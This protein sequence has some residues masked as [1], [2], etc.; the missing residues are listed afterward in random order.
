[1]ADHST[2]IHALLKKHWGYDSFRPMQE[3]IITS[4]LD[5]HDT[6]G[7]L[8]TGGGKSI[9]FQ[10]PALALGGLTVVV[11][12]LISLMKDQV[13]NLR[14]KGILA[15]QLNHA[16]K[17]Y[18]SE[19]VLKRCELGKI[20]ILYLSPEK[21]RSPNM[22][23]W[24]NILDV[25]LIVVDEA[26]CISQW[27]YDFRPSY[28]KIGQLRERFPDVPVL[29]L[30]ASAT[31]QVVE[32]MMEKLAFRDK[33]H[34]FHLSFTRKNISYV[35]RHC[36]FKDV[37]LLHILSRVGG[38]GIV[39]TRSRKRTQ[40]LAAFL[41]SNDVSADY[42]HA[43]LS[44][45]EKN[46]R[47]NRWKSGETRIIVAT[48]AFGMGIDKPDVRIV[49]HHDLPSSL[50]E[51]Y[52]EA[53]RAGRDGLPSWAVVLTT[54]ADKGTLTRRLSESYPDKEFIR[55]TYEKLFIFLGVGMEEGFGKNFEFQFGKFC[56]R[57][58]LNP[59]MADSALRILSQA[60]YFDYTDDMT[61]PSRLIMTVSR[62]ALY[63]LNGLTEETERVLQ[64]IL[65]NYSGIF[66]DYEHIQESYIAS[67]LDLTERTVYEA[68]LRMR[69]LHIIDY[70]PRKRAPYIYMLRSREPRRDV[71]LP[72]TVYETRRQLME[73][74]LEAMK[75]FA[76]ND[77]TCRVETI[78]GYFGEKASPCGT[79]DVC[80]DRKKREIRLREHPRASYLSPEILSEAIVFVANRN[81]EGITIAN[82]ATQLNLPPEEVL[83]QIRHLADTGAIRLV[84]DLLFPSDSIDR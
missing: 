6:L 66:A 28:L 30:T 67:S 56:Q 14:R 27:G 50:E 48:N 51:Y 25:R 71:I 76:F 33:T 21:L 73:T 53:G 34:C 60:G 44:P 3:E 29:A 65:R 16:M 11:T 74:R 62:R 12:P 7:L 47:Q 39:Y 80:R 20:K 57:W 24:W 68:L 77:Y 10:I 84:A 18:E 8:P 37:E 15:G 58:E 69:K 36:E 75:R 2:S 22:D 83:Q 82:L 61:S 40:E 19:L 63:D 17:R 38:C 31:P 45:E 26:H 64:F 35:V 9:T 59:V 78:L 5:G 23:A 55:D 79:C 46:E 42:Y 43:G 1:M 32:D 54:Q 41:T 70:A 72:K 49:I 52:Q 4:V 13:D 81:R